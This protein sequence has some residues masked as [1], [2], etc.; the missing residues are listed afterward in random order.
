MTQIKKHIVLVVLLLFFV[1]GLG[2][3]SADSTTY[4]DKIPVL[5]YHDI[6]YAS[7]PFTVTP[8]EFEAQMQYLVS[9]GYTFLVPG[10][11][12]LFLR[13]KKKFP[14]KSVMITFDDG[15]KGVHTYALPILKKV[16]VRVTLF[17]VFMFLEREGFV[18]FDDLDEL[19]GSG[20]FFI[21][22]HTFDLHHTY[23]YP[24]EK[25]NIPATMR[26]LYEPD[27]DYEA[28]VIDDLQK[29]KDMLELM[30]PHLLINTFSYPFGENNEKLIQLVKNTGFQYAFAYNSQ[31][32]LFLTRTSRPYALERYPIFPGTTLKNLV[33]Q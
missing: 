26:Q 2:G 6:G 25:R 22:S 10:D 11:I 8:D 28:R 32:R 12:H 33:K 7:N 27:I 24:E 3:T 31:K 13:S 9:Q 16:N 20:L 14:Q 30:Y 19:V 4:C 5:T 21:G 1:V 15:C 17:V 29:S 18:T 23:Y